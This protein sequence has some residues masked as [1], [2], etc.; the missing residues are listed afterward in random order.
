MLCT[1]VYGIRVLDAQVALNMNLLTEHPMA[2][3]TANVGMA[4]GGIRHLMM[5]ETI[6]IRVCPL[7][8]CSG[9]VPRGPGTPQVSLVTISRIQG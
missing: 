4:E 5:G 8:V 6:R 1:T 9:R 2:I 3:S 7:L